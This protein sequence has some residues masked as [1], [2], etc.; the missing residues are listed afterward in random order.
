MQRQCNANAS[1]CSATPC[2][3]TF[4]I[5]HLLHPRYH[6]KIIGHILKNKKKEKVCLY[7]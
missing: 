3:W 2:G 7:S 4:T 5:I 1:K 6:P